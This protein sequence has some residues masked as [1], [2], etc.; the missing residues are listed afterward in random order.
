MKKVLFFLL[1]FLAFANVNAQIVNPVKWTNKV[2]KIS[3]T[4]FN[5]VM[6]GK[7]ED[8]WHVYSQFTPENGPLPAEFKF[9]DVKGNFEIGRAHV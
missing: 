6:E 9:K 2:D 7:I 4:E 3:D 8:G 5:L 1:S